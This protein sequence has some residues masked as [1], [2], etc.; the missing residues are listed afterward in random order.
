MTMVVTPNAAPIQR[1]WDPLQSRHIMGMKIDKPGHD[2]L[3]ACIRLHWHCLP[4]E[5]SEMMATRPLRIPTSVCLEV[6]HDCRTPILGVSTCHSPLRS[7]FALCE[8]KD[9]CWLRHLQ[10]ILHGKRHRGGVT[11]HT[12]CDGV[13]LARWLSTYNGS[14]KSAH[15][16]GHASRCETR[17]GEEFFFCCESK[18]R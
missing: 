8:I 3:A 12:E 11:A 16:R 2:P 4:V 1:G 18:S 5:S 7:C 15:R 10:I 13:C 14:Q 17:E 6:H 9:T